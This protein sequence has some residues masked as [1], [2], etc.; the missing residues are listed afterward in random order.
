MPRVHLTITP[1]FS[2]QKSSLI[3]RELRARL[4]FNGPQ[5]LEQERRSL[6]IAEEV[7]LLL[8]REVPELLPDPSSYVNADAQIVFPLHRDADLLPILKT[9]VKTGLLQCI[10]VSRFDCSPDL[11]VLHI[12]ENAVCIVNARYKFHSADIRTSRTGRTLNVALVG[13]V[14]DGV[15]PIGTLRLWVRP[16]P[17]PARHRLCSVVRSSQTEFRRAPGFRE[18]SQ[19]AERCEEWVG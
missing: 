13:D 1:E 2:K 15:A 18:P 12:D 9:R 8:K 11:I 17:R 3:V 6:P 5:F 7:R 19:S 14:M 16:A 10:I 4:V